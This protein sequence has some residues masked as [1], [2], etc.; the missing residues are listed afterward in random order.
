MIQNLYKSYCRS[1]EFALVV[2]V[3]AGSLNNVPFFD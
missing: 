1:G 2:I 3:I